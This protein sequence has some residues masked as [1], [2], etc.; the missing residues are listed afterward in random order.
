MQT[1]FD[2]AD[3]RTSC[4]IQ[5]RAMTVSDLPA[6]AAIEATVEDGWSESGILGALES[7][8]ARCFVA[9]ALPCGAQA[10]CAQNEPPHSPVATGVICGFCACSLVCDTANLD[11]VSV[12]QTYRR[13]GIARGL[14]SFAAEALHRAGAQT[15]W[16]EVRSQNTPA[17]ALYGALGFTQNGLRRGFYTKPNDDAVLMEKRLFGPLL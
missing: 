15:L 6:A 17:R 2:D 12:A 5:Y 14:L 3:S 9:V 8:A 10:A 13:R 16:L 11:A 1:L 4:Q 7:S